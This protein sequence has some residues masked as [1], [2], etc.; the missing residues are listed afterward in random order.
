MEV[1]SII[2]GGGEHT[3]SEE[4][5]EEAQGRAHVMANIHREAGR[6]AILSLRNNKE[7]KKREWSDPHGKERE[8]LQEEI[9]NFI[10]NEW[11]KDRKDILYDLKQSG[12]VECCGKKQE[13]VKLKRWNGY[14]PSRLFFQEDAYGKRGGMEG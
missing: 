5:R 10:R 13:L 6:E 12:P 11:N 3:Q 8:R 9:S 4:S 2:L 14:D 1:D 7:R